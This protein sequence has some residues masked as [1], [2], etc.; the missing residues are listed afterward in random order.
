MTT[1]LK[2]DIKELKK[3]FSGKVRDIYEVSKNQWLLV[4]TDRISAFD[5][6]FS[7]GIPMKGAYLNR[8]ANHWFKTVT[9]IKTHIISYTPELELPFL[10]NYPGIPER[11]IL[12]QKMNRLPVEC[13][14]RGFLFGSVWD[15]YQKHS[16][17]S[18]VLLPTGIPLAGEIPEPIFTPSGKAE[19][20]HDINITEKEFFDTVGHEIGTQIKKVS[21]ELYTQ[22]RN[23]MKEK[24]VILADTKFEFGLDE[25]GS[26]VLVD[27]IL[28]PDS[29]RYWVGSSYSVGKSPES[30]DKQFVRDYLLSINWNKQP[31][32]PPLP[33]DIIEN[34]RAKYEQIA[35]IVESLV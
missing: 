12:V 14:V 21:L 17:A 8:V 9:T 18:G 1:I 31:P 27:E 16:T 5:V 6:V 32:A 26:L 29:S 3:L 24:G 7:E 25:N 35:T 20:G 28:T 10:K 33:P 22:A 34:T 15:E 30:F 4:T 2:T 13:I 23:R 19:A 11:S